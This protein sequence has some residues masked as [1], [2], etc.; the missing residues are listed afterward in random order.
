MQPA[1]L[2][3]TRPIEVAADPGAVVL[4]EAKA[5]LRRAGSIRDAAQLQVDQLRQLVQRLEAGRRMTSTS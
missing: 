1:A 5:A 2:V 3:V 4:L